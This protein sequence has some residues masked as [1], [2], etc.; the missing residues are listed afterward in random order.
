MNYT[1][2][3]NQPACLALGLDLTDGA[4][5]D[6][7]KSMLASSK[8]ETFIHEGIVYKWIAPSKLLADMPILNIK[9]RAL[10]GRIKGLEEKGIIDRCPA[11][12]SLGKAY[13]KSG[14][15]WD[16]L[17]SKQPMQM[18][19][20]PYANECIPPM[21]IDAHPPMQQNAHYPNTIDNNTKDRESNSPPPPFV[22]SNR[23]ALKATIENKRKFST[24]AEIQSE[25]G[26]QEYSDHLSQFSAYQKLND[27]SAFLL[28]FAQR[29]CIN[30]YGSLKKHWKDDLKAHL[31]NSI[32]YWS[33]NKQQKNS[34]K[35]APKVGSAEAWRLRMEQQQQKM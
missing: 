17:F 11:N 35:T 24:L 20:H 34:P 33:A 23:K 28:D 2:Y 10:M 6:S 25:I 9:K 8:I 1:I 13:Y 26:K 32:Q 18:N 22:E 3:I 4:I 31:F 14:A 19:A 12:Q 30:E 15:N 21:Q 27:K 29:N 7:I 16:N 5:V